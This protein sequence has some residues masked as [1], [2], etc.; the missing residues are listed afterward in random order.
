MADEDTPT[1]ETAADDAPVRPSLRDRLAP[2]QERFRALP[3]NTQLATIAGVAAALG[4]LVYLAATASQPGMES[5]FPAGLSPDD[6]QRNLQRLSR[7]QI[8]YATDE[9]EI[10]VPSSE[11]HELRNLLAQEGLPASM[12]DASD[13]L[14]GTGMVRSPDVE[15]RM[16][17]RSL[18]SE[19][20]TTLRHLDGV[21]QARVHVTEAE[22][23]LLATRGRRAKAA[24]QLTLRPGWRLTDRQ[25]QG[26]VHLV[27][28]SVPHLAPEDVSITDGEG[29]DLRLAD[30]NGLDG[31]HLAYQARLEQTI[32]EKVERHIARTFGPGRASVTVAADIDF[33]HR[34]IEVT[35]FDGEPLIRSLEESSERD[36]NAAADAA[37]VPGAATNLPGGQEPDAQGAQNGA[38][39]ATDR[40]INH[41][42][43]QTTTRRVD[44]TPTVLR[45][46][47]S[48]IVDGTPAGEEFAALSE[49]ELQ[50]VEQIVRAAAGINDAR[51]DVVSVTSR[52]LF[53]APVVPDPLDELL[54]PWRPY[55][56]YALYGLLGFI[57]FIWLLLWRRG[58]KKRRKA[59]AKAAEEAESSGDA[60][61]LDKLTGSDS[62]AALARLSNAAGVNTLSVTETD[63]ESAAVDEELRALL[64]APITDEN[65]MAEIQALAAEL[66]A[67]DPARAARILR[68]WMEA[69]L[70]NEAAA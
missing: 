4:A 31:D 44:V 55:L 11:V 2:L 58:V 10:L 13:A 22:R 28:F 53:E 8:P 36:P 25:I 23:T 68:G 9:G 12:S 20:A 61:A 5:L 67:E 40:R 17:T 45:L 39:L 19:L 47:V 63:P 62:G 14:F 49:E 70:Q 34:E 29:Q 24:V 69:D 35:D 1:A 46:N 59:A 18:Q 27:A 6:Q 33:D 54:G 43:D 60:G 41:E 48:A 7:Q 32:A 66:A 57:A 38:V 30:E 64:E 56:P 37:G 3:A 42:I 21:E 26:M 51:G 50:Q 16:L 65:Q 52:R 15:R